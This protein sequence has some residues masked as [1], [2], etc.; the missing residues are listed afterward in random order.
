MTTAYS[1]FRA[2][3]TE[4]RFRREDEPMV[5]VHTG[6]WGCGAYGGNRILMTM[7]Q[8]LAARLAGLDHLVFHTVDAAGMETYHKA[9]SILE[10]DLNAL[11]GPVRSATSIDR[12]A[13]MGFRWGVSDGN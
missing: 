8:I 3:R 2:A 6:F 12:T 1:G 4:S 9:V 5:S 13:A 11:K 10:E 7:L